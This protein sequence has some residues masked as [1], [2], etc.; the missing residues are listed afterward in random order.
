MTS[1]DPPF[2]NTTSWPYYTMDAKSLRHWVRLR[3]CKQQLYALFSRF[4]FTVQLRYY[5]RILT[6]AVQAV[7]AGSLF[8]V[9]RNR[10][11]RRLLFMVQNCRRGMMP[12][13]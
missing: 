6:L 1:K 13:P 11:L 10:C 4:A 8:L 2:R 9:P 12:S 3:D 5:C 7:R